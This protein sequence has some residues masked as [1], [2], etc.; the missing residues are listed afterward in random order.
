MVKSG[1]LFIDKPQGITSHDVVDIVRHKLGTRKIGHSGTL[2]PLATGLL[3]ILIEGATKQFNHFVNFD[4]EYAARLVLGEATESGDSEG[5]VTQSLNFD[6]VTEAEV[7]SV[8]ESLEGKTENIP[9]MVSAIKYKGRRLYELARRGIT[10]EREARIVQVHKLE[11]VKFCLPDID[12]ILK[13]SKGTYVR[14]L[15][16]EI[17]RRLNCVGHISKIRRLTIGPYSINEAKGL[18]N[19]DESDIRPC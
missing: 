14:S 5:K 18:D 6:F 10:V 2:D 1:M 3:I 12:F 11:L 17:A 19:F 7:C 9:P 15:A 8:F 16:E 13:C 4:K